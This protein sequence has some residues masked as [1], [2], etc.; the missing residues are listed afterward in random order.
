MT[1]CFCRARSGLAGFISLS[2]WSLQYSLGLG[3]KCASLGTMQI[4]KG[5][6]S[7][8]CAP[9]RCAQDGG[10][11]LSPFQPVLGAFRRAGPAGPGDGK[12]HGWCVAPVPRPLPSQGKVP[13]GAQ[14][15]LRLLAEA[16]WGTGTVCVTAAVPWQPRGSR[17]QGAP[18][19]RAVPA[20]ATAWVWHCESPQHSLGHHTS[21]WDTTP[22]HGTPHQSKGH[23]TSPWDTTPLHGTPH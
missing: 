18:R 12:C 10:H 17:W 4:V 21:P 15:F 16:G 22:I 13:G 2:P 1:K 3:K 9:R 19:P 14:L 11:Q 5:T 8:A 20:C 7:H 6:R 23:H